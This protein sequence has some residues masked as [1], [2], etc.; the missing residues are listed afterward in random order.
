MKGAVPSP[1]FV[2]PFLRSVWTDVAPGGEGNQTKNV[3]T[4]SKQGYLKHKR[5]KDSI[6]MAKDYTVDGQPGHDRV[7]L[8]HGVGGAG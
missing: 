7:Q 2:K 1:H 3:R 4:S 5:H 8:G 6:E